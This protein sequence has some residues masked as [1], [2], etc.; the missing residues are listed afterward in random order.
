MKRAYHD[1][2][3]RALE[4]AVMELK[5]EGILDPA[6]K[7]L[8]TE[9]LNKLPEEIDKYR[10]MLSNRYIKILKTIAPRPLVVD[11][12]K[13]KQQWGRSYYD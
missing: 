7:P 4:Q 8:T 10:T 6:L 9:R 3:R 12:V 5:E 11:N 13:P 2:Q 1:E